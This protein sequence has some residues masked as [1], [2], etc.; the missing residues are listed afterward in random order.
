LGILNEE[1][2]SGIASLLDDKPNFPKWP[3]VVSNKQVLF[4]IANSEMGF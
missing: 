3:P 2:W 4:I 1:T